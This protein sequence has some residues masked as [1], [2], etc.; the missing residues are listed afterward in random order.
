MAHSSEPSALKSPWQGLRIGITGVRGALGQAL[1][2]QFLA[3]GAVVVGLSH[4]PR[5][6]SEDPSSVP[7][8]WTQ[9]Q[10]DQEDAL[11]PMLRTLDVLVL[12]HGINPAGDQRSETLSKAIILMVLH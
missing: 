9:W 4:G 7:Q 2:R 1:C 5:P 12:N 11:D 6:Q 3:Q 10:C 8:E